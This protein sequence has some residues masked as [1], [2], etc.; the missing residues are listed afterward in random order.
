MDI[1]HST[2]LIIYCKK[3]ERDTFH[4]A[5]DKYFVCSHCGSEHDNYEYTGNKGRQLRLN[6]GDEDEE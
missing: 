3:C 2:I 6:F 4:N 1:K 5:V